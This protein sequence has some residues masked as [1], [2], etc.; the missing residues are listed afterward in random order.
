MLCKSWIKTHIPDELI[1]KLSALVDAPGVTD[2][3]KLI[4]IW[5]S[6]GLP[7][8]EEGRGT[9][10]IVCSMDDLAIKIALD[11]DG[12]L[13][14]LSDMYLSTEFGSLVTRELECTKNGLIA[15][16]ELGTVCTSFDEYV[17]HKDEISLKLKR[18]GSKWLIGD[19]GFTQKN[20]TN[21]CMHN[22][23]FKFCDYSEAF[24]ASASEVRCRRCGRIL[25]Y[26]SEFSALSCRCGRTIEFNELR[27]IYGNKR[28]IVEQYFNEFSDRFI[29]TD[30][31]SVEIPF[32]F[33]EDKRCN[34][35]DEKTLKAA[36][37]AIKILFN[38][39]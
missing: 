38:A 4:E 35:L 28:N 12:R 20:Y 10:R 5:T 34:I 19:I 21:G 11:D 30:N 29:L 31:N 33:D 22:G 3:N 32:E 17:Q 9:N 36:S 27:S 6:F 13:D 25:V 18:L 24:K 14:N 8:H 23:E 1:K 37:S 2:T 39:D 16:A 15:I 26:N 7:W